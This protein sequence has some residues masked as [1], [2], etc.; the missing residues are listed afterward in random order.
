MPV[1]STA[2]E[3]K[4]NLQYVSLCLLQKVKR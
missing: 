4:Q 1:L 2:E 3:G